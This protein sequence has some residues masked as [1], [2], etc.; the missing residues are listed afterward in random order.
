MTDNTPKNKLK[1]NNGST[2]W[3]AITFVTSYIYTLF[4]NCIIKISDVRIYKKS[5]TARIVQS[6]TIGNRSSLS[7]FF[8]LVFEKS[9]AI[10][11]IQSFNRILA[12]LSLNAYGMFFSVYGLTSSFMYYISISM[13]GKNTNGTSAIIVPL[14]IFVCSIPMLLTGR[15]VSD[16]IADSR[17]VKRIVL[18]IFS[19]PE[20]KLRAD[21]AYGGTE[22]S[23]ML[24][25]LALLLGIL[26]Y[27]IHPAYVLVIFGIIIVASLIFSNPE[28]G[29]LLSV[30]IAPFLQY[31]QYAKLVL[32][33]M[34][35]VTM[36]SYT[37]KLIRRQRTVAFS[38]ESIFALIFCAFLLVGSICSIDETIALREA[39]YNVIVVLGGFFL[40]YNLL[41]GE[42]RLRICSKILFV[43]TMSI[44]IFGVWNVFYNAIIE[45]RFYSLHESVSPIFENNTIYIADSVS[46][47]SVMA[48]LTFPVLLSGFVK[49]KS[50]KGIASML[51]IFAA[52]VFSIFIYGSY[53]AVVVILIE[54]FV[55]W[56]LYSHKSLSVVVFALIPLGIFIVGY[57]LLA[58][59]FGL[60][61]INEVIKAI[62]PLNAPEAS[63]RAEVIK[64]SINMLLDG[65]F[66]GIGS[67]THAFE[68]AFEEYSNV[69]SAGATAPGSFW[70]QL[71][72]WSGIG[73]AI[74]FIISII[75]LILKGMATL[76]TTDKK[77]I[78][79]DILALICGICGSLLL[80]IVNC[81]WSD[82][83]MMYLFW[84]CVAL[85]AGYIKDNTDTDNKK[86]H[87]LYDES[88]TKDIKIKFN[89]NY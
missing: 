51:V 52:S 81:I 63:S 56:L 31:T 3:K 89:K 59:A 69:I 30:A 67:G 24:S 16:V 19:I 70:L 25:I 28:T 55:F 72:C 61:S 71:I 27:F 9:R 13:N 21:K 23:F 6:R 41:R 75:S 33:I 44:Y 57:P 85:L 48:A 68:L 12:S 32:I 5:G 7:K 8:E 26:T 1:K 18:H 40:T 64:G 38:S 47:F 37:Q 78:R 29:V 2:L 45:K 22:Y 79:G 10:S 11:A 83:R 17:I 20:E 42:N 4:E 49:Q 46:V 35:V 60:P 43:S 80:G 76:F 54:F 66:S 50:F 58:R 14:I 65:N 82:P 34:I 86:S 88:F 87:E 74:S 62:L 36:L 77:H 53:E 39:L 84:V 73:G 15:S